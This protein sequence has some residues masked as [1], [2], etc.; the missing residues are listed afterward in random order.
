[1]FKEDVDALVE[2]EE[3]SEDFKKKHRQSLKFRS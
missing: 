2:G 1:M 3:L